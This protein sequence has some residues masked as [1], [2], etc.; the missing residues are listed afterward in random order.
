MK[1]AFT[2]HHRR[3]RSRG[4]KNSPRNISH[5]P[6]K[7]HEAWHLLFQ[8]WEPEQIAKNITEWYLDP[9]YVMLA[10]RREE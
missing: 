5:I 6:K 8:N 3:P 1:N 10:V 2:K 4:G 9:D 7:F